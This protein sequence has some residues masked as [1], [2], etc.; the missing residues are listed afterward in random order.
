MRS[1]RG[2]E[3]GSGVTPTGYKA[4]Q[5]AQVETV[6]PA[7]W[8]PMLLNEACIS[9]ELGIQAVEA[10][11]FATAHAR[12]LKAQDI[13]LELMGALDMSVPISENLYQLYEFIHGLLVEGNVQKD[14][15]PLQQALPL[16]KELHETWSEAVQAVR[17]ESGETTGTSLA[18]GVSVAR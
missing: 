15:V 16:L 13:L 10:K 14:K 6:S 12:L 5:R 18:G 4:Y 7:K 17:Q 9:T 3:G 2:L 8:I 11:D 1:A